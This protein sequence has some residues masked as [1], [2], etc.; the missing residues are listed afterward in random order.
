MSDTQNYKNHNRFHAPFHF[1]LT[2]MLF[3]HFI[4]TIYKVYETPDVDHAEAVFLAIG[5]I[6]LGG[7]ARVNSLKVQDRIIRLEE[8]LRYN[9]VLPQE[10]AKRAESL[11]VN[12]IIALRFANDDELPQLVEKTLRGDFAKSSDIKKSIANWRGDYLRV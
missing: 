5:L 7:L 9:R 2:P 10:L 4:Y 6:I 11:S 1:I 12:Q 3:V 8:K